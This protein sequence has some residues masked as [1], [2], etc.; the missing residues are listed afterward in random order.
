M[1]KLLVENILKHPL[2]F[3]WSVQ[4][5]G[6]LR[7]YL[8][9]EVRLHVWDSSLKVAGASPYHDHPWDMDS[10][11]VAGRY[12]QHRYVAPLPNDNWSVKLKFNS[13]MIQ[14]GE[15]AQVVENPVEVELIEQSLEIYSE[16]Q[17][18]HQ[19]SKEIHLSCPEDGTV[20][21]VTRT[22]KSDRDHATVLWR[23]RGGWA[24]AK[25]RDATEGEILEVT[26]RALETWF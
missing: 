23:G 20:T 9:Q 11:I 7:T 25:P 24:S 19:D 8:S 17:T 26:K 12:K 4:G 16:G 6:M 5:L 10:L 18:Y 22:F 21:L 1:I 13:A 3:G 15:A 2:H 14:C